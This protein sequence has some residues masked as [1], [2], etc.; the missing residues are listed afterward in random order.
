MT[1]ALASNQMLVYFVRLNLGV[2]SGLQST[3][4]SI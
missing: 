1:N 4:I 3:P 2:D